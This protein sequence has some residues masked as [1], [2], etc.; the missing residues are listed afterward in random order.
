MTFTAAGFISNLT[1]VGRKSVLILFINGRPVEQG[2]LKRA[3]EAVYTSQNPKASKPWLFLDLKMPPRHVEVNVHPTK[4][5]VGFLYQQDVI[6]HLCRAVEQLLLQSMNSRTFSINRAAALAAT[7]APVATTGPAQA[8][9]GS[10]EDEAAT[11][12]ADTKDQHQQHQ[13][14]R[15]SSASTAGGTQQQTQGTYRPDKLVRTDHRTQSLDGFLVSQASAAA[16]ASATAPAPTRRRTSASRAGTLGAA[17]GLPHLLSADI[18]DAAA[19]ERFSN[20]SLHLQA[21]AAEQ[22]AA[23]AELQEAAAAG[24]LQQQQQQQQE[25]GRNGGQP[26]MLLRATRQPKLP[27]VVTN[28]SSVRELLAECEAAA[29][30]ELEQV[31]RNHTWVGM[32]SAEIGTGWVPQPG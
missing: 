3:M 26:T 23:A 12:E 32:V 31:L 8:A 28:L 16:L 5:E 1:H 19:A 29:H 20:A 27:A 11:A 2:Q 7:A 10:Q 14:R 17:E 18:N 22:D 15:P 30:G 6:D 25:T 9:R 24:S 21:A 4:K 13:R